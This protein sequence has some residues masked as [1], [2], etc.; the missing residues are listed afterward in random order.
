MILNLSRLEK[1]GVTITWYAD[2]L[3]LIT[4]C[5]KLRN[6]HAHH[7]MAIECFCFLTCC[8]LLHA[9]LMRLT[10]VTNTRTVGV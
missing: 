2:T 7:K 1:T 8:I 6:T 10:I 4:V 5:F 3:F 9:D